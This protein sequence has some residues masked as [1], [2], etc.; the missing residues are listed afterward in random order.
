MTSVVTFKVW[1]SI[2]VIACVHQPMGVQHDNGIGSQRFSSGYNFFMAV[3]GLS[4]FTKDR[5]WLLR[6]EH[7]RH[8]SN[9]GG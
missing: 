9:F 8:V 5:P 7:G 4:T 2:N 1:C 6:H 3:N